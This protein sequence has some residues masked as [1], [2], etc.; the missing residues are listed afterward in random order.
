MNVFVSDFLAIDRGL[1]VQ[2]ATQIILA[3]G[4]GGAI[5][6]VGGGWLAQ[7]M[8]N[9]RKW[10]MPVL[11]GVSTTVAIGPVLYIINGQVTGDGYK[12][13]KAS[14]VLLSDLRSAPALR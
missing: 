4:A 8:Y 7:L 14:R 10:S 13:R 5:G 2:G 9:R 6:T 11:L 3:F 12:V 1:G